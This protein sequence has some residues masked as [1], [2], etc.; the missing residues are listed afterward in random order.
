MRCRA[1]ILPRDVERGALT[2]QR[3]SR[4]AYPLLRVPLLSV[5]GGLCRV[6][7]AVRAWPTAAR[8]QRCAAPLPL[9]PR[10]PAARRCRGSALQHLRARSEHTRERGEVNAATHRARALRDGH[11]ATRG[12]RRARQRTAQRR[13]I[14]ALPWRSMRHEMGKSEREAERPGARRAWCGCSAAGAAA[15]AWPC[16]GG[17]TAQDSNTLALVVQRDKARATRPGPLQV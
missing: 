5:L 12:A 3:L 1:L 16:S 11:A 6:L 4:H 2:M 14:L 17:S 9:L 15:H 8:A 13:C 10:L 7:R